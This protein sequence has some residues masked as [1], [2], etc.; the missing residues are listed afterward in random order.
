MRRT[1]KRISRCRQ[2]GQ[3]DAPN[4]TESQYKV[5][6]VSFEENIS[7]GLRQI[8]LSSKD[9]FCRMCGVIPGDIDDISGQETS[10]HVGY[11][12]DASFECKD[13]ISN[14]DLLCST[15]HEGLKEA[16]ICKPTTSRLL[17]QARR[18][19]KEEQLA[20]FAALLKKFGKGK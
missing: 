16:E 10:F 6:E 18:T 12:K 19:V 15:C 5:C 14:L 4:K 8:V 2:W 17:S 3:I 11:A 9:I 20:V 13:D 7:P 1:V